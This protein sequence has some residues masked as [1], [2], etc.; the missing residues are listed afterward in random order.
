MDLNPSG[1]VSERYVLRLFVAACTGVPFDQSSTPQYSRYN[2]GRDEPGRLTIQ[3]LQ[4]GGA[5]AG[6]VSRSIQVAS[7]DS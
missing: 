6:L 4:E 7:S 2:P 5:P 3:L 1:G